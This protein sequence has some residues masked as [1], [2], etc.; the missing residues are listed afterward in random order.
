MDVNQFENKI[1]ELDALIPVMVESKQTIELKPGNWNS[2]TISGV[3]Y[4]PND[5][6]PAYK[7]Y[8]RLYLS[9]MNRRAIFESLY[10]SAGGI[11]T[12]RYLD[13]MREIENNVNELRKHYQYKS[14]ALLVVNQLDNPVVQLKLF[15]DIY[16]CEFYTKKHLGMTIQQIEAQQLPESLKGTRIFDQEWITSEEQLIANYPT[17]NNVDAE[18]PKTNYSI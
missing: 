16:L 18:R 10:Y 7:I 14:V 8:R 11:D 5:A 3:E 17:P 2:E 15:S 13:A 9:F 4:V 1:K 6:P 12:Q